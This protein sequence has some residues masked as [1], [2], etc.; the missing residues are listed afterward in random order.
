MFLERSYI[1]RESKLVV[2]T[3]AFHLLNIIKKYRRV[4]NNI[5]SCNGCGRD[6]RAQSQKAIKISHKYIVLYSKIN[7]GNKRP[8]S[9][10]RNDP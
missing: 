1:N 5:S 6:W 2:R 8:S 9:R 3:L 4:S 10:S 7:G